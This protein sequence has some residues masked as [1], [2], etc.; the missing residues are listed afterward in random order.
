M[1]YKKFAAT[2]IMA[3]AATGIAAGTGYAAPAPTA[4][5]VEQQ[6]NAVPEVTGHDRGV[7]YTLALA[8]AGKS[9]VTTVSGGAFSLDAA[10]DAVVL[11]NAAGERLT[12]IPLTQATNGQVVSIAATID[13][14][15]SRLTLTP[16]ATPVA[17]AP[18]QAQ[19][20]GAQQWFMS[21]LQAA[22][23]GAAVGAAIGAAVGL[24]FLGVGVIPGAIIG[25][26]IG[27]AVAGG[28]PLLDSAIA[29]FSGQP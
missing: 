27:L 1:K 19:F 14:D 20:I 7:D 23:L 25:A 15:N 12:S 24:L 13:E 29:Y 8:E 6:Q 18:S 16:R 22:S 10:N 9:L 26:G 21:E 4:P 17:G 5:A 28:P 11:S 3:A 2:A